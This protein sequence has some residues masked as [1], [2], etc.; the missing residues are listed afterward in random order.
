MTIDERLERIE[1]VTAGLGEAWRRD[2][3]ENRQLWR[4]T[5]QQMIAED[6]RLKERIEQLAEESRAEDK[7]LKER[8]EQLAEE[9]K[10]SIMQLGE[11]IDKLVSGIGLLLRQGKG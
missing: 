4:D 10:E 9:S 8:I 2:Q 5:Q 7:R 1:H 3:E 11:R 6:K